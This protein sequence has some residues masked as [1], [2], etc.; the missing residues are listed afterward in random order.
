[1]KTEK[2][3]IALYIPTPNRSSDYRT[4]AP[5]FVRITEQDE[6]RNMF[7]WDD[8]QCFS[9]LRFYA[10]W[11][12]NA[13]EFR[14]YGWHL[15]YD[16][17]TVRTSA[18]AGR[19]AKMLR[20]I[21]SLRDSLPVSPTTF[22]QYVTLLTAGLGVKLAVVPTAGSASFYDYSERKH[23]FLKI[24][25]ESQQHTCTHCRRVACGNGQS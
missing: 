22:G 12:R 18:A 16:T 19:M 21:E 2:E 20:K 5:Y 15:E 23:R 25:L 9:D 7:G 24:G 6:I 3:R 4:M 10:Q 11:D 17:V 14:A 8:Q 13:A 1:M